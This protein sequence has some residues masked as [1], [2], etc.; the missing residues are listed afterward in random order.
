MS[1]SALHFWKSAWRRD[2]GS[3]LDPQNI[4]GPLPFT[5]ISFLAL[6]FTRLHFDLGPYRQLETRDP[7]AMAVGLELASP[8]GR[9]PRVITALLH[10]V[11]T[12][13]VPVRMGVDYVA[14]SQMFFWS[15][16]HS[17]CAL[18]CGVFVW[19]WLQQVNSQ[20][21]HASLTCES[22][23]NSSSVECHAILTI[24]QPRKL[25]SFPGSVL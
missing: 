19:K 18:E 25:A 15:C 5:S 16:Q 12:M 2:P 20:E 7:E 22:P 14:R 11:H 6:A 3:T 10:A 24:V 13:S 8:P 4:D 23:V 1:S 17:I 21:G 9:E